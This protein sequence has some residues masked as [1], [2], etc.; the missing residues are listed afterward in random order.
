MATHIE[1]G[2]ITPTKHIEAADQA[3]NPPTPQVE[4]EFPFPI[5]GAEDLD[6]YVD[7]VLTTNGFTIAFLQDETSFN[8]GGRVTFDV[9]LVAGTIVTL[10]RRLDIVRVTDFQESG[11]FRA[12][13]INDQLDYL[14]AALQQVADDQSRSVQM[15]ITYNGTPALQLPTPGTNQALLWD[16]QGNSFVNGPTANEIENAQTY[17]I[18][19]KASKDAAELA[20]TTAKAAAGSGPYTRVAVLTTG[21]H[22][23]T[24]SDSRTYYILDV[25]GGDITINLPLIGAD[26]GTTFGFQRSGSVNAITVVPNGTDQ[27]NGAVANYSINDDSEVVQFI[28][29]DNTPD[30]WIATI[31][32]QTKADENFTTKTG[33]TLALTD[34]AKAYDVAF[35]AG[36]DGQM[37]AENLVVQTYGE[38]VMPR[39]GSFTGEAGYI[40][41]ASTGSSVG[42]D[43]LKNG[44]SI[45]ST[46][47][48]FPA[49]S[50]AIAAGILKTDGTQN[51]ASG[52]RITFK[53]HTIGSAT[54]GQG[55]RFTVQGVLV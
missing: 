6:V 47:P 5:F 3:T 39:S 16:E 13:V 23:L 1:I 50:N 14:T 8:N 30:N 4:F 43:I 26:E 22:T 11:E 51:F 29:D 19:A 36:F 37:T 7:G 20:A 9:G 38:L 21:T 17:S 10:A 53:V 12:K 27:I 45:Y 42:V 25:A 18:D 49:A 40:D 32:S 31:Q 2:K 24:I 35:V 48:N 28:A 41:V 15:P 54:P 44:V 55:V 33:S 46:T 34:K 52:D